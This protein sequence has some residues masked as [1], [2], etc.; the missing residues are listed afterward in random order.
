VTVRL[1]QILSEW[2][3]ELAREER[4]QLLKLPEFM[5]NIATSSATNLYFSPD[6][7][8]LLYQA[9]A[10]IIIPRGLVQTLPSSSTQ[11]ESREIKVG[12]WYVYDIKEDKNFQI[13]EGALPT[14]SPS[15]TPKSKKTT[16]KLDSKSKIIDST[17]FTPSKITLL[18]NFVDPIPAE[19]ISSPSAFHTLQG[20]ASTLES[21]TLFNAQYSPIFIGNIQWF[22]DSNH[23]IIITDSGIDLVEYD[24]TNRL[25][26]YGGPMDK[27]IVYPW[28]D[29]SKIITRLAFSPDTLPNL[30]TIKLK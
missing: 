18:P 14:P 3:L 12:S 21:I 30:Y 22:P 24:G 29:G 27:S 8:R 26:V 2:E 1:P 28:P 10:D 5:A 9:V 6:S 17:A 19:L 23:L 20:S 13:A 4:V 25:T 15:A 16:T 11:S 7:K